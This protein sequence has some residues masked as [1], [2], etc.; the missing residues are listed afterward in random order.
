MTTRFHRARPSRATSRCTYH[1]RGEAQ[2]ALNDTGL[3]QRRAHP[4]LGVSYKPA[5]A[6]R[7][8]PR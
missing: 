8:S 1:G 3:S 2:R 5:S 7:E 6:C 4:V